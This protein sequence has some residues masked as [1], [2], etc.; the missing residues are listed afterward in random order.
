MEVTLALLIVL[1]FVVVLL[2]AH[3]KNR[4]DVV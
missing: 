4:R 3:Q 1:F 2:D